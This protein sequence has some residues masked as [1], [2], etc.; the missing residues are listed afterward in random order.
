[1]DLFY[2]NIV[3]TFSSFLLLILTLLFCLLSYVEFNEE[4]DPPPPP[5]SVHLRFSLGGGI[6]TFDILKEWYIYSLAKLRLV[7]NDLTFV[8][9][10]Y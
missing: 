3:L 5:L 1:M 4:Q 8:S 6:P 9:D 2:H 7:K 10:E